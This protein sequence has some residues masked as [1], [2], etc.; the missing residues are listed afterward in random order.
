MESSKLPTKSD[1]SLRFRRWEEDIKMGAFDG[2]E[3][4]VENCEPPIGAYCA[5]E[6]GEGGVVL[7][8]FP[9]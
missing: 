4:A 2:G 6:D 3:G 1:V 8:I 7:G 5:E 9:P